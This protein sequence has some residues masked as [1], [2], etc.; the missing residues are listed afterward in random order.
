MSERV[1]GVA[2]EFHG[3]TEQV[4]LRLTISVIEKATRMKL[5]SAITPFVLL[6]FTSFAA[7]ADQRLRVGLILPLSGEASSWG[8]TFQSAFEMGLEELSP[9]ERARLQI[10]TEDDQLQPKNAVSAFHKLL[11]Q[12]DIDVV[13]NLSSGTGNALASLTEQRKIVLVAIAS[14][15]AIVRGRTHAFN[16]WVTPEEE[17]RVLVDEARRQNYK[18]IVRVGTIHDGV[19]AVNK[20]FDQFNAGKITIALD[21][22]FP[23][24]VRDFRTTLGKIRA[25]KDIDG[26]MIVL[27]PGQMSAFAKQAR[28][29]GIRSTFFG[30]E[31]FEDIN[32]IKAA[33]GALEGA[34][35]VNAADAR[36]DFMQRFRAKHPE[37]SLL[38]SANGYDLAKLLASAAGRE[39]SV[40]GVRTFLAE[41]K[42]FSG[43]IGTYSSTGDGRFSLPAAV[44]QVRNNDFVTIRGN[45]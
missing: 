45:S 24:D 44:K 32:E 2:G 36:G 8:R 34:W 43:V 19:S 10:F 17:A 9:A 40:E 30:W 20:A 38:G 23:S 3:Y 28:Q 41:L 37:L 29:A 42:D 27:F 6:V 33:Q 15:A 14:D 21:E 25:L 26:I 35:Y 39:P 12:H 13:V 22:E 4:P 16:F 11:A 18:R 31:I 7:L 1:G 5:L